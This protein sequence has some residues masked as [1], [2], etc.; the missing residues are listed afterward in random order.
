VDAIPA[1]LRWSLLTVLEENPQCCIS[2]EPRVDERTGR[3]VPGTVVLFQRM[4]GAIGGSA[5][6]GTGGAAERKAFHAY[7]YEKSSI[8]DWFSASGRAT[9]PVTRDAVDVDSQY[10][11]LA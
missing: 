1:P 2:L 4:D 7:L 11:T 6:G 9:N 10:F 3:V 5:A 8:D